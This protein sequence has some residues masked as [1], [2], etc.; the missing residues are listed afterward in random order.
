MAANQTAVKYETFVSNEKKAFKYSLSCKVCR[1]YCIAADFYYV[2][3]NLK[4]LK[5]RSPI[6]RF[7]NIQ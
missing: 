1:D 7:C 6:N 2:N 4:K 3:P 5:T